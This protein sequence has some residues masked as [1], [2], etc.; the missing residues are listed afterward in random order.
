MLYYQD[1]KRL[2]KGRGFNR[3]IKENHRY[4]HGSGFVEDVVEPIINLVKDNKDLL[5]NVGE[6]VVST[7]AIGKNTKEIVD[8]II[9]E[10]KNKNITQNEL[11]A[12]EHK[13]VKDVI[14]RIN[15]LNTKGSG[16]AMI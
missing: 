14:K 1:R 15:K 6:S 16:F 9:N 7:H 4:I 13:K 11:I 10:K 3:L 8:S 2:H 5:K 12:L